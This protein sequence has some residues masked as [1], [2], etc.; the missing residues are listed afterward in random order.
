MSIAVIPG[1]AT[2][3]RLFLA[4]RPDGPA[5]AQLTHLLRGEPGLIPVENWH[6]TLRFF[7]SL[8]EGQFAALSDFLSGQIFQGGEWRGTHLGPFPPGSNGRL[9]ALQGD[10]PRWLQGLTLQLDAGLSALG[11]EPRDR[12]FLPHVSLLHQPGYTTRELGPDALCMSLQQMVLY[13]SLQND[14]G[15]YYTPLQ[16]IRLI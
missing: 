16:T 13:A 9:V 5:C 12:A 6:L 15:V 10:S 11:F 3:R 4:L 7:G 8:N 1:A 2:R 14:K